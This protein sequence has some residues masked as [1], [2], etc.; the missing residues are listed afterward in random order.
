R[1][2]ARP[3][4][5]RFHELSSHQPFRRRPG[6][7][8]SRPDLELQ[9]AR[10]AEQLFLLLHADLAEAAGEHGAMNA[11]IKLAR[12]DLRLAE[13]HALLGEQRLHLL[14]RVMPLAHAQI[15]KEI[16]RKSTRLYSSHVKI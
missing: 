14:V 10:A 4:L 16:D 6:E 2:G 13:L 3:D 7:R 1:C 5:L 8:R 15:R 12:L 11:R 9:P